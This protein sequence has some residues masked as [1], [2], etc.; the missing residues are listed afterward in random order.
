MSAIRAAKEVKDH[1]A[2]GGKLSDLPPVS[3]QPTCRVLTPAAPGVQERRLRPVRRLRPFIQ[4]GRRSPPHSQGDAMQRGASAHSH[5]AVHGQ[6]QEAAAE[7][8]VMLQCIACERGGMSPHE[9]LHRIGVVG[10]GKRAMQEHVHGGH[11]DDGGQHHCAHQQRPLPRRRTLKHGGHGGGRGQLQAQQR[12]WN[13]EVP[14]LEQLP[15]SALR[16]DGQSATLAGTSAA[17]VQATKSQHHSSER[18]RR[19]NVH[20]STMH[21][22]YTGTSMY[23]VCGT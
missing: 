2:K 21:A 9:S 19:S 3:T 13:D 4:R 20:S 17:A 14:E 18:V 8:E 5:T 22:A 6:G 7:A 10:P 15:L 23:R 1:L 12:E 16:M 11:V